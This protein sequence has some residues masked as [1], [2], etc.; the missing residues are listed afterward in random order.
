M[1]FLTPDEIAHGYPQIGRR[2]AE[3]AAGPMLARAVLA[4]AFIALA[5]LTAYSV[6]ALIPDAGI[7]KLVSS[8][9]FPAGLGMV[10]LTGGEL[11]T[12]NILMLL[13]AWEKAEER[14]LKVRRILR[15]WGLVYLG[16]FLG[17]LLIALLAAGA[18][19]SDAGYGAIAIANAQAH[20]DMTWFEAFLRGVL[21]NILVCTAVWMSYSSKS[22]AGILLSMYGPVLMFVL[23]GT[24]H[25][26]ANMFYF[27]SGVLA[28]GALPAG[29]ML[30]GNLLPVT[31]GNIVGGGVVLGGLLWFGLCRGTKKAAG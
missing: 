2:K 12:G 22:A 1:T 3:K 21:C 16:N 9:L 17:A 7:A 29:Q 23:C 30:L 10:L 5:C 8:V 26:V 31:L 19:A 20:L 6:Q 25:C 11:F 27:A 14:R 24:E 18:R 4:G 15:C 13:C 28:G